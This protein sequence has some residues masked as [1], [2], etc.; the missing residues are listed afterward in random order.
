MKTR[1]CFYSQDNREDHQ[2]DRWKKNTNKNYRNNNRSWLKN[3]NYD[4][5]CSNHNKQ[6][7]QSNSIS[8]KEKAKPKDYKPSTK[9][10]KQDKQDPEKKMYSTSVKR[11]SQAE[12]D[13]MRAKGQCFIC[14]QL[15]H[16]TKD[17]LTHSTVR[18]DNALRASLSSKSININYSVLDKLTNTLED[19]NYL[20]LNL[21]VDNTI[22][23][24]SSSTCI[25][26][27]TIQVPY[28]NNSY[29]FSTF[30]NKNYCKDTYSILTRKIL[31][32]PVH[33]ITDW[34]NLVIEHQEGEKNPLTHSLKTL[35][36]CEYTCSRYRVD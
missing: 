2:K 18:L 7:I 8:P 16:L 19:D 28:S 29:A 25:H 31:F 3:R 14:K 15:T 24:S 13:N 4:Y 27:I 21:I 26:S 30:W 23:P 9:N 35:Y 36:I 17:C 32:L 10:A 34:D 20:D 22:D 11:Y 1:N 33:S 6:Y 12:L 5:D